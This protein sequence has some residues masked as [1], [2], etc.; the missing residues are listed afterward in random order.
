MKV[1]AACEVRGLDRTDNQ[2][3]ATLGEYLSKPPRRID[4]L[5][6]L[7]LLVAAPLKEHLQADSGLYLAATYPA[8]PNMFALLES[9]CAQQKLPKPF[10]FVNSVSNA[11][12]FHVAQQ[13]GM[14]GPNL[15][16]GAG[17]QVWGQL[18]DLAGS[19]LERAQVRQALVVLIEENQ[20]DG[21]SAYALVLENGGDTLTGRDF[22]S[23]SGSVEAIR[24]N[25]G[26]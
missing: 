26:D 19:D 15:F 25:L 9:V 11:A 17:A 3:K 7:A 12:G 20:L 6:L 18:L 23:L 4:R 8:R 10:E 24:L 5:T 14:Q 1:I 21:F 13:L 2:L 22:A 16:I